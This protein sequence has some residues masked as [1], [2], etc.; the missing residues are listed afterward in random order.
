MLSCKEITKLVSESLDR[1]LTWRQRVGLWMHIG[2]CGMCWR[3]RK[4]LI[5]IH[6]ETRRQAKRIE[7]ETGDSAEQLPIEARN[8][9]K[10]LLESHQ[11]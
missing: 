3:F 8:R 2:M 11:G 9:M 7:D 5:H 1:E 6:E 4:D 10:R